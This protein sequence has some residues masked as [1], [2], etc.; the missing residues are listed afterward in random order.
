MKKIQRQLALPTIAPP[1]TGPKIGASS[2]GTP[3]M[4]AQHRIQV[5][6]AE[7][8][9]ATDDQGQALATRVER[10]GLHVTSVIN[11]A[12]FATFGPFHDAD[13]HDCARRSP[14]T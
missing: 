5:H 6:V 13:R 12:G 8:D 4:R 3:T 9:L 14:S 1:M 11:N 2:I 7:M 10:L